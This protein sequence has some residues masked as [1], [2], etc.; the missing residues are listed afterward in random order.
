ML[1]EIL[2]SDVLPEIPYGTPLIIIPDDSLGV[3]PYEMLVLNDRGRIASGKTIPSVKDAEFFGD[4][5]PISYY[6][7]IT[8]LTLARTLRKNERM[9]SRTLVMDDPV[10]Q[11]DDARLNQLAKDKRDEL[12]ARVPDTLM[13]IK[14]EIGLTFPRLPLTA[15]LGEFIYEL[16][17]KKT[18]RF[19]GLKAQKGV[20]FKRPL[21]RYGAIVFATHGYAGTDL[22]GFQ[23]PVLVLTLPGQPEG[24]DG[25]LR[26]NEALGLKL[27]A[28]IV[29]LTACQSG[30]GR[31]ISGE[32][33]M[34]MGRAF[35]YAGANAVLMSLWSVAEESSVMLV[36]RFF[37]HMKDGKSK[38][39]ALQLARKEI[40]EAGY[41]HP[42]F[43]APF[44]SVG[45]V[46]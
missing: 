16:D 23:E 42:F 24:Q 7:S 31:R 13:S 22:P 39:A 46:D 19:T 5:N 25:F 40:R 32:G 35:Q 12:P 34:G 17:K 11:P 1:S 18:D 30:L 21:D 43:W 20:L 9:G 27:N 6:Q 41:D 26:M 44:I 45:E 28:D 10:F 33:T 8:A 4:R 36:E 2:L 37:K 38:R 14:T 3:L 15:E 29:A